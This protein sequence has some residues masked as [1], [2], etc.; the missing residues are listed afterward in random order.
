MTD[1]EPDTEDTGT[2]RRMDDELRV[3]AAILR[4]IEGL[5]EPAKGRVMAYLSARYQ[6]K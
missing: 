5:E 6:G 2:S 1:T 3:I 4:L